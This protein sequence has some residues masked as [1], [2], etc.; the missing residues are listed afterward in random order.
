MRVDR[1]KYPCSPSLGLRLIAA[2]PMLLLCCCAMK[3]M[4]R[5]EPR[6]P[7]AA[8]NAPQGY[9]ARP[10]EAAAIERQIRDAVRRWS[11]TPHKMGGNDRTGIDCSGFVQKVYSELFH[12]HLPRSTQMQV[13]IGTLVNSKEL[14]CGDLIFFHPPNKIRHVGIYLSDGEF[15]HASASQ[16]VTISSLHTPYWRK[17]YWTSK[18]IMPK[19]I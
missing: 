17:A 12:I 11:G 15:A 5:I 6:K 9:E 8:H 3:P 2:V 4:P 10:A 14:R 18:R 13:Q 1:H 19:G 7:V 16:G